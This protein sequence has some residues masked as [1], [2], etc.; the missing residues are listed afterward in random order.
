[1]VPAMTPATNSLVQTGGALGVAAAVQ[2]LAILVVAAFGLEA[3]LMFS[4]LPVGFGLAGLVIV[5]IGSVR[6]TPAGPEAV[7]PLAAIFCCVLGL[8]GGVAELLLWVAQS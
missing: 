8:L 7:Q 3:V 5:I 1:M 2:A 6:G 4:M